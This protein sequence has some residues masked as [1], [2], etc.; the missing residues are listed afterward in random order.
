M[1]QT[2]KEIKTRIQ[3]KHDTEAN[4]NKS[5]L[6]PMQG[7]LIIYDIDANYSYERFKIGDG[8]KKVTAL[9]FADAYTNSDPIVTSIGGI[10]AGTTFTNKP[11]REILTDLLYPY[12]KPVLSSFSLDDPAGT[13]EKGET[14]TLTRA[15]VK[16]TKKSKNISSVDLY[17][18]STKIKTISDPAITTSGTTVTFDNLNVSI[19]GTSNVT[20]YIKVSEKDGT[21]DVVDTSATYTFVDPYYY[22]VLDSDEALTASIVTSRFEKG[23]RSKGAHSYTYTTSN[24]KPVIVY[25]ASYGDLKSITDAALPY[26][27][28]KTSITIKSVSYI[29]YIG[30]VSTLTNTYN[31][32][33]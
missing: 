5:T 11:I 6:V 9:P 16:V 13:Y 15:T 8:V 1:S 24:Q 21:T 20:F 18:G 27:W 12:T 3:N 22:G 4:W 10:A 2:I 7:E 14:K 25:P 30:S 33:Y 26:S 31:F 28:T 29:A 17:Q 19:P 32:K 23:I